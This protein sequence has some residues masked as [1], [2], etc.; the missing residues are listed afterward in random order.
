VFLAQ[1][2]F[3]TGE[4]R[5]ESLDWNDDIAYS[6]QNRNLNRLAVLT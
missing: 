6:A 2:A 3:C 5:G 4:M 1:G